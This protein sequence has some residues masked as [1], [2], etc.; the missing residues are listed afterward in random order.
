MF[1]CLT[2]MATAVVTTVV[3]HLVVLECVVL[4]ISCKHGGIVEW[5]EKEVCCCER[6]NC[7]SLTRLTSSLPT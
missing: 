3:W 1:R 6:F 7:V 4:T 2:T 5:L